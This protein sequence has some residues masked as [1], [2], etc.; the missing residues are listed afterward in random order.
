M[1]SGQSTDASIEQVVT[2][3]YHAWREYGRNLFAEKNDQRLAKDVSTFIFRPHI[4][5]DAP[6]HDDVVRATQ[7]VRL[8]VAPH[9][10]V[11]DTQS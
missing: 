1:S 9:T 6:P 11:K 3:Y 2:D 7:R 4:H 8:R 10:V 5:N